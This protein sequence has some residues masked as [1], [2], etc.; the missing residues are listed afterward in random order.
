MARKRFAVAVIVVMTLAVSSWAADPA[1]PDWAGTW[2]AGPALTAALA[3]HDGAFYAPTGL[4]YFLGGRLTDSST[5]GSIVTFNPATGVYADTGV[6]M[7]I[8]ISNY[9]VNVL[10]DATGT[11]FYT[12][13]GRTNAGTQ[14]FV[15]QVYY[16]ATGTT[17]QLT[18]ADNYPGDATTTCSA[19]LSVVHNNK[20]YLAGGFDGTN[21][22]PWTY[23][24]DPMAAAGSRWTRLTS[25]DLA[26]PRAY[27]MGAV[28]DGLIYAIGGANGDGAGGL[29]NLAIV[30]RLDPAAGAPSWNDAAVADLPEGCS[31]SR[32]WGFD[33]ASPYQDPVDHTPLASKIISG[34]GVWATPTVGVYAYT[35]SSNTWAAFPALAVARRDIAAEFLPL[36]SAPALWVWGGYDV[37]GG[38][39]MTN[40]SE[41]F[42]LYN[43]VPVELQTFTAD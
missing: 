16:P 37:T 36:A 26:T 24:F 17:A 2:Q 43:P 8:P 28:V 42:A 12:F 39:S 40:T 41:Y 9:T 18:A 4:V 14:N 34:C 19:S 15:T 23:V 13:C 33:A 6:D 7:P 3:R 20:A 21:F 35:V 1:E 38:N 5:D 29:A 27:I 31:S 11:G 25:A 10:T 32:A 22:N 30:E